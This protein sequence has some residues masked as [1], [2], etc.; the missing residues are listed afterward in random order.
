MYFNPV[1]VRPILF[2]PPAISA[3]RAFQLFAGV[4]VCG[5]GRAFNAIEIAQ[6]EKTNTRL[7]KRNAI[8]CFVV[9]A[10]IWK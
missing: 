2:F 1:I 6:N 5:A 7:F 10:T 4:C 8:L 9:V 3:S